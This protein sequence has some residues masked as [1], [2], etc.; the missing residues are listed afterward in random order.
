RRVL[1]RSFLTAI[2]LTLTVSAALHPVLLILFWIPVVVLDVLACLPSI[3]RKLLTTPI[4]HAV[5]RVL[6]PL[7]QTER[8]ALE[9][10]TVCWDG[11]LFSGVPH[12][13]RLMDLPAPKLTSE[14]QA[15][16]DGPVER[17]CEML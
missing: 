6:P 5:K 4:M 1:F 12:W 16:L 15:F 13:N 17:L 11:E 14:E 10:G 8:E 2:M 9:A 7:S 3:R